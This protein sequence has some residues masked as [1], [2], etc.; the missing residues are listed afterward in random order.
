VAGVI[1]EVISNSEKKA[2]GAGGMLGGIPGRGKFYI[3]Y[4]GW[5]RAEIK[6]REGVARRKV[7]RISALS[8]EP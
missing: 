1:P 6:G 2:G 4:S 8:I 5:M 3:E 7:N